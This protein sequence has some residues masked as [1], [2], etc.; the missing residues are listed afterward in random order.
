MSEETPDP[1]KLTPEQL[2]ALERFASGVQVNNF[3]V[4]FSLEGRSSDGEKRSV[5]LSANIAPNP[6]QG[7]A[8]SLEQM[9]LAHAI[10]SRRVVAT[11]YEDAMVRGVIPRTVARREERD[12]ILAF[13]LKKVKGLLEALSKKTGK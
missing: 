4:S 3:T 5:F 12:T 1:D 2:E 6:T 8:Y 13:Y 11:L 10:V 7:E 9:S